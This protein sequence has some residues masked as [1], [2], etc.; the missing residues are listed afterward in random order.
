MRYAIIIGLVLF[1]YPASASTSTLCEKLISSMRGHEVTMTELVE[2]MKRVKSLLKKSSHR[3]RKS[4]AREGL[5]VQSTQEGIE[6]REDELKDLREEIKRLERTNCATDASA[7]AAPKAGECPT[8]GWVP[9]D[10]GGCCP[11]GWHATKEGCWGTK[12]GKKAVPQ[13]T[14][15]AHLG[16]SAA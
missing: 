4:M 9:N 7:A 10:F 8:P 15:K 6:M 1:S 2:E 16:A 5:D 14:W 13:A 3:E 12:R 11:P